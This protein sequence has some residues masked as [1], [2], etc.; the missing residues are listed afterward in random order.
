MVSVSLLTHAR[1]I[2]YIDAKVTSSVGSV[3]KNQ[4]KRYID[5]YISMS[6]LITIILVATTHACRKHRPYRYERHL[7][8]RHIGL[9][10]YMLISESII[11]MTYFNSSDDQKHGKAKIFQR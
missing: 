2:V 3:A 5:I 10:A 8:S 6:E 4:F 1:N 7:E 11:I 9:R